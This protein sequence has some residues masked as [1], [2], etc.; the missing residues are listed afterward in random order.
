VPFAWTDLEKTTRNLI[1]DSRK[2]AGIPIRYR[3]CPAY[4]ISYIRNFIRSKI[5]EENCIFEKRVEF[6]F[7]GLKA[8]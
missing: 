4:A 2:L 1:Q 6:F 3:Q 5:S 7:A 8:Q